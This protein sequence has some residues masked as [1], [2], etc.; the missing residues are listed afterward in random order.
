MTSLSL[1]RSLRPLVQRGLRPGQGEI[2]H[3]LGGHVDQDA[4]IPGV[5]DQIAILVTSPE[6]PQRQVQ[7][8]AGRRARGDV[9][10]P[11][12]RDEL[13][14]RVRLGTVLATDEAQGD[15]VGRHLARVGDGHVDRLER[16]EVL[17]RVLAAV[18]PGHELGDVVGR[19][20]RLARRHAEIGVVHAEPEGH[21]GGVLVPDVRPAGGPRGL[22]RTQRHIRQGYLV[23]VVGGVLGDGEATGGGVLPRQDVDE[24]V[25]ARHARVPTPDDGRDVGVGQQGSVVDLVSHLQHDH[26]LAHARELG[27][28]VDGRGRPVDR[29][30]VHPLG[31][32][33][34]ADAVGD[35]DD[36]AFLG[37]PEQFIPPVRRGHAESAAIHH[38][39]VGELL[40]GVERRVQ[41]GCDAVVVALHHGR[42]VGPA[43][44]QRDGGV[45]VGGEL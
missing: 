43:A 12:V 10:Q 26:R 8:G 27:N 4:V 20:A 5:Q 3:C 28:E 33:G 22:V 31:L 13:L 19:R 42:G 21:D 38:V 32:V 40:S 9:E 37:G 23:D 29:V 45:V 11:L 15:E 30:P 35:D 1:T 14:V 36:V 44:E 34:D 24:G 16:A 7:T 25:A 18:T 17:V 2:D 39:D 6:T 41:V